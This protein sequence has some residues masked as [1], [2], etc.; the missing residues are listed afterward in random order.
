METPRLPSKLEVSALIRSVDAEGGFATVL[1][2]GDPDSGSILIVTRAFGEI[3][4]LYERMPD[5]DGHRV[6]TLTKSEDT[7]KPSEFSEY[8]ERRGNRDPDCWIV[9]L[10]IANAKRFIE[11]TET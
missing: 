11:L 7:E 10:D 4:C 8:L 9:E 2:R 5:L 1:Q 6:W 3:S